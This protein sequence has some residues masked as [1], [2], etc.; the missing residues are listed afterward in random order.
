MVSPIPVSDAIGMTGEQSLI[1]P[2]STSGVPDLALHCGGYT[3]ECFS[4]EH[5]VICV[6]INR[7]HL[8]VWGQ[9]DDVMEPE[10]GKIQH[11]PSIHHHLDNITN[12]KHAEKQQKDTE[13]TSNAFALASL[14]MME[15]S[16]QSASE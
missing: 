13:E 16:D 3:R 14:G 15:G 7:P 4:Q 8:N 10:R 6:H 9:T 11:I 2:M 5:N 1:G 12:D